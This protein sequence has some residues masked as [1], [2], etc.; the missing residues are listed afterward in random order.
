MVASRTASHRKKTKHPCWLTEVSEAEQRHCPRRIASL[1]RI[2]RITQ[3]SSTSHVSK[4]CTQMSLTA[5][6]RLPPWGLA[7][8]G[9]RGRRLQSRRA[10]S[11]RRLLVVGHDHFCQRKFI[12]TILTRPWLNLRI[13]NKRFKNR[14]KHL[15][16][17]KIF[18]GSVF[19]Q[20]FRKNFAYYCSLDWHGYRSGCRYSRDVDI[21]FR[22]IQTSPLSGDK[23]S[24]FE[25]QSTS[26]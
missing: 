7:A 1:P 19:L 16:I 23:E 4:G 25:R 6:T 14:I 20:V 3:S 22:M 9:T 13:V 2:I 11:S 12:T 26:E 15:R 18:I 10:W 8:L 24:F 5:A 17:V 21:S